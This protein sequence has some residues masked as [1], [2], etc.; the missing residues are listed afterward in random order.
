[1]AGRLEPIV[2]ADGEM[3]GAICPDCIM[4]EEQQAMDEDAMA[5]DEEI[6]RKPR[7]R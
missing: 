5:V 6:K 4:P 7:A 1:V 2:D 3:F